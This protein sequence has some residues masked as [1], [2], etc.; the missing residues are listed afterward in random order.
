MNNTRHIGCIDPNCDVQSVVRDAYENA[1]FLCDQY[2]LA[3]PD[4]E[5]HE[6]N[7]KSI[8]NLIVREI[9]NGWH[10]RLGTRIANSNCLRPITS[11]SH[12][13]RTVQECHAS[14]C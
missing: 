2:Y 13:V 12:I 9:N 3:S 4:I 7:S 14:S 6:H 10:H 11:L 5:V 8:L 1:K